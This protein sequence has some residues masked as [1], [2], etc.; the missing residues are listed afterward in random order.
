[1]KRIDI[2]GILRDPVKR[3]ELFVGVIIAT[4]AREGI[5]T[6]RAQAEAAYDTVQKERSAKPRKET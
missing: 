3:R 4:Q 5:I 1:M 6:T 2:K